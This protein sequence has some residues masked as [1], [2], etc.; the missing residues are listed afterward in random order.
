MTKL[1][2]AD[3]STKSFNCNLEAIHLRKESL[4]NNAQEIEEEE[5]LSQSQTDILKSRADSKKHV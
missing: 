5:D 2:C 3:S 4:R 1:D